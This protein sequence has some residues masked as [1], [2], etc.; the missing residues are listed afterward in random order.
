MVYAVRQ[1]I[2]GVKGSGTK[3]LW[4]GDEI[5][6]RNQLFERFGCEGKFVVMERGKGIRGMRKV[7][8]YIGNSIEES[9]P[10]PQIKS[11]FSKMNYKPMTHSEWMPKVFAAENSLSVRKEIKLKE[12]SD[13]DLNGLWSS[14][15]DTPV[16]SDD[17]FRR[18]VDDNE[19][20]RDEV[21]R[22]LHDKTDVKIAESDSSDEKE[23]ETSSGG[24]GMGTVVTAGV[25]GLVAGAVLQEV[26]W[27]RRIDEAENRI[28]RLE[29]ML[30]SM[31]SNAE[32]KAAEQRTVANG[33][34]SLSTHNV[35]RAYNARS[36][37]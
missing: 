30:D 33:G 9:Q 21:Y 8:E 18:F 5:P 7:A 3:D 4:V 12:L 23:V 20:L 13:E 1:Y 32:T 34:G 36:G 19:K 29:E 37:F 2:K 28:R 15:L 35:L 24:M 27:K 16:E 14:M 25:A 10:E 26:R 17:D 22:R 6:S 11:S 31:S